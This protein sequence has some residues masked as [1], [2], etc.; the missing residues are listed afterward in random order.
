MMYINK[1]MV[2][3][4]IEPSDFPQA[5]VGVEPRTGDS[6][7]VDIPPSGQVAFQIEDVKSLSI[8]SAGGVITGSINIVKDFCICCHLPD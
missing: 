2:V 8:I 5:Q 3:V 7:R 4:T 1:A 6:F